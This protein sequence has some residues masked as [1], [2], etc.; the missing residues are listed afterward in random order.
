MFEH[1]LLGAT[2]PGWFVQGDISTIIYRNAGSFKL[3]PQLQ[4]LS[5]ISACR[6]EISPLTAATASPVGTT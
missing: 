3:T 5:A 1:Y 4:D 2:V 6:W